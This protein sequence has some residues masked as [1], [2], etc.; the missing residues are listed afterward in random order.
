MGKVRVWPL[1]SLAVVLM[2]IS[3]VKISAEQT[4][5]KPKITTRQLKPQTVLYTL[6]RGS[7]DKMGGTIGNLYAL[8]GKKG[9]CPRGALCCAYLNN[10]QY[11]SLS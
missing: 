10:P 5:E 1:I 8:A 6:Y 9:V 2:V 11:A 4:I 7:Y 3:V